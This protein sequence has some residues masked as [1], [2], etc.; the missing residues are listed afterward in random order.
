MFDE[1]IKNN[2]CVIYFCVYTVNNFAFFFL[3]VCYFCL[4]FGGLV[5]F[6]FSA[7]GKLVFLI[8]FSQYSFLAPLSFS[9]PLYQAGVVPL[10]CLS[11]LLFSCPDGSIKTHFRNTFYEQNAKIDIKFLPSKGFLID[12]KTC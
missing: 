8:A 3:C 4:F 6:F 9:Q 5:F 1:Q 2:P 11:V 12:T 10:D 7:H